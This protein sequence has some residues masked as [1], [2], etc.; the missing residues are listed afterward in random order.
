MNNLCRPKG[1]CQLLTEDD[2]AVESIDATV[3]IVFDIDS[4]GS[5][6]DA[7]LDPGAD[8]GGLDP[9]VEPADWLDVQVTGHFDHPAART[10]H[11]V[12]TEQDARIELMPDQVVLSCRATFVIG[13]I[14]TSGSLP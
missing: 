6:F 3:T 7:V 2:G 8:V 4:T 11:A 9:G 13:A 1:W 5:S 12:K 10:C 14:E